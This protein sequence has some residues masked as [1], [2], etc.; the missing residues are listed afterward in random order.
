MGLNRQILE[1][2]KAVNH[3]P[4]LQGAVEKKVDN[5]KIHFVKEKLKKKIIKKQSYGYVFMA[6]VAL[7][8]IQ[9]PKMSRK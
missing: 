8:G 5:L 3:D 4:K 2:V 9:K 6:S 7:S 1:L